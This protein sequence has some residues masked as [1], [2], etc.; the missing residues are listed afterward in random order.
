MERW[1]KG[2]NKSKAN[3]Q[4]EI[5][6]RIQQ[7]KEEKQRQAELMAAAAAFASASAPNTLTKLV[8]SSERIPLSAAL[9]VCTT[10]RY[11]CGISCP[12]AESTIDMSQISTHAIDPLEQSM[13]TAQVDWKGLTCLLCKRK[14]PSRDVLN[15]HVQFSDLHKVEDVLQT[16]LFICFSIS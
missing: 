10:I 7:E 8:Q 13:D 12:Q 9:E 4:K 5:Q 14:F 2:V 1:A 6:L 16:K 3:Q 15:K 11:V